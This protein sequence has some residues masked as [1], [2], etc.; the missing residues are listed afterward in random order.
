MT[1]PQEVVETVLG[2]RMRSTGL[3]SRHAVVPDETAPLSANVDELKV[4]GQSESNM[5]RTLVEYVG[6]RAG[7]VI[8]PDWRVVR[9]DEE[10]HLARLLK[11]LEVDCVF[12][13]GANVGQH[14]HML[15]KYVGYEGRIISFEPG[16]KAFAKLQDLA[17]RDGNWHAEMVALGS[18]PGIAEF[19]VYEKSEISSF[20]QFSQSKHA[21]RNMARETVK[22]QVRTLEDCFRE[23]KARWNFKRAYLKLDTQGSDLDIVKSAGPVIRE[24]VGLQSEIAFRNIY[25]KAPDFVTALSHYQ[26]LGFSLSRLVPIHEL[27]FPDLVE[28]DVIMVRSDFAGDGVQNT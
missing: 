11:Y 18:T 28:M 19:T 14:G 2:L 17:Q 27:H 23:A 1:H 12:D 7:L 4:D 13:V 8:V 22:V 20:W 9:L 21:P 10:R 24:F 15:R 16:P 3:G 5:L 6:R 26:S 25:E